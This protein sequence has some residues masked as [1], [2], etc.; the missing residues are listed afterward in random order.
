MKHI[1]TR[2]KS[3][4]CPEDQGHTGLCFLFARV[5]RGRCTHHPENTC[6]ILSKDA[7]SKPLLMQVKVLDRM[8]WDQLTDQIAGVAR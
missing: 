5:V 3:I 8:L 1:L 6:G 4:M 2:C 7:F